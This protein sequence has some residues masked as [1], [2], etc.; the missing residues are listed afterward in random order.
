MGRATGRAAGSA[1][2]AADRRQRFD[3]L[4]GAG[5]GL[6]GRQAREREREA[7]QELEPRPFME[8]DVKG[9]PVIRYYLG[10]GQEAGVLHRA[11]GPA[12]ERADGTR[13]WWVKGERHREGGGPAIEYTGG[14]CSWWIE[15]RRHRDDGPAVEYADGAK[16]WW[17]K[18]QR[19]REGGPAVE[20]ADGGSEWWIEGRRWQ[21]MVDLGARNHSA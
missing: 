15:G 7:A 4:F 6:S 13:E 5:R 10:N 14:T 2:I 19:H 18:G 21:R 20:Y 3:E 1:D 12:V 11:D 16:E 17:V 8:E 9:R